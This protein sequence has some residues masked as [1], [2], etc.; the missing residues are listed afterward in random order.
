MKK[1]AIIGASYLQRPLVQKASELGIETHVFAWKEGNCV[2]DVADYFYPISILDKEEILEVCTEIEIDGIASIASD[3][4][5]PA[6][7][8]IA[9]KL[10]LTGNTPGVTKVT[11][12][13]F[14]MRKVL[15]Q[16]GVICPNFRLYTT[17]D[18]EPSQTFT[19]PVIVKPTD[20]SGSRRNQ[21]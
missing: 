4:A 9:D 14:E 11:T 8:Y 6:V 2:L 18:F 15:R 19:F 10:S 7:N 21:S 20:R 17:S 12:D 16:R 13:K 3:I 5:M 1:I